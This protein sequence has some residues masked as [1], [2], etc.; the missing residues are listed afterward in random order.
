MEF[1]YAAGFAAAWQCLRFLVSN[2]IAGQAWSKA[3][4]KQARLE[5]C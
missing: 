3:G 4:R 1:V 5:E 2:G